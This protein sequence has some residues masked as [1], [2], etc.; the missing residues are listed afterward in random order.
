M[1]C[2]QS[3][4]CFT[5]S[6]VVVCDMDER[7][8]PQPG[9]FAMVQCQHY[10]FMHG[11]WAIEAGAKQN[12]AMMH[13]CRLA[14]RCS[15]QRLAGLPVSPGNDAAVEASGDQGA[16]GNMTSIVWSKILLHK[17]VTHVCCGLQEKMIVVNVPGHV[18][19][20]GALH[21]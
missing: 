2:I 10:V 19:R 1:L 17:Y 6:R 8:M 20:H 16:A 14:E 7:G 13:S 21:L 3:I 15:V 11:C 9:V 4:A 18:S 12:P 5:Q